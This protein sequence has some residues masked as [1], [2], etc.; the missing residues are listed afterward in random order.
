M[1]TRTIP[2]T[3]AKLP[4]QQ[5]AAINQLG[6][7]AKDQVTIVIPVKNEEQAIKLVIDELSEE[8]YSNILVVDG[9]SSDKTTQIIKEKTKVKFIEQHGGGKTGAVKTAIEHVT[10]P[11]LVVID[12]DY[13]YLAKDIQRLLNHCANYAQVIGVRNKE[14]ISRTH[15]FGNWI[16]TKSFNLLMGTSLSDI[17]SGMYLLKTDVARN[18]EL[19]S[20]NFATEV[21]IAAQTVGEEGI[22]EVPVGYRRRLGRAKLSWRNGFG[23]LLSIIGLARKYNP[24]LVF[25]AFSILSIIPATIVLTWVVYRQFVFGIWHSGWALMGVMLLLFA[26]QA[27]SITTMVLLVKRTEKRIIQQIRKAKA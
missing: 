26:S 25:S 27:L 6:A 4:R 19:G 13:T 22:T 21:E 3:I 10:T 1:Y 20:K 14:N 9:Y 24:L 7:I 23:I 17:C 16:I 15:R 11:Y 8:G 18:M 2:Q 5:V 12:G